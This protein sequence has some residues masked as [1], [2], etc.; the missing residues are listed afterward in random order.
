ML[1]HIHI[2][3]FAIVETL[4]LDIPNKLCV[5]TGETGAGKSIMLDAMGLA[6]GDRADSDMVRAGTDKSDIHCSFNIGNNPA[7]RQ[8][9]E[10]HDLLAENECILRRVIHKD[11]RSKAYI[12]G[13]PSTLSSVRDLGELIVSIHGQH[14]HQALL[15][16]D[17][18]R[19]LLDQF[20]KL[21]KLAIAVKTAYQ[22][23][24][25]AYTTFTNA[26]DNAKELQDRADPARCA[27]TDGAGSPKRGQV[28]SVAAT[29][30]SPRTA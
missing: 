17:T 23:W 27:A 3:N 25:D 7:A 4:D 5:I 6:L 29:Q 11:G 9:L 20:G 18:H 24:K 30:A 16:K 15:K 14:E 1:T 12:N 19:E 28:Q 10:Q 21:S 8:W 13:T 2:N 26:R 22:Q